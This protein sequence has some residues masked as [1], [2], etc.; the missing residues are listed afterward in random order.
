MSNTRHILSFILSPIQKR[1]ITYSNHLFED[2]SRLP[3]PIA[4]SIANST[5][6]KEVLKSFNIEKKIYLFYFFYII[7]IYNWFTTR[8]MYF[9]YKHNSWFVLPHVDNLAWLKSLQKM[10]IRALKESWGWNG[11]LNPAQKAERTHVV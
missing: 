9:D 8:N 6:W 11:D 1:Q 10:L 4:S 2:L 3:S 7:I 5:D